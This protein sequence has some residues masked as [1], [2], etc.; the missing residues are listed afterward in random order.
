MGD[1]TVN[2]FCLGRVQ[3]LK[4]KILGGNFY[5]YGYSILEG[6]P[7]PSSDL[8]VWCPCISFHFSYKGVWLFL[9]SYTG[10]YIVLMTISLF[11]KPWIFFEKRE[12]P[13]DLGRVRK[14][15]HLLYW[16]LLWWWVKKIIQSDMYFT[17]KKHYFFQTWWCHFRQYY[18]K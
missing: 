6:P 10:G 16:N 12:G 8:Q 2:R 4:Q 9:Q 17:K 15:K 14:L 5:F 7:N 18:I 1:G 11:F 13:I 3:I